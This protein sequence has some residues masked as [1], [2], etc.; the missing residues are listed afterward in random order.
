MWSWKDDYNAVRPHSGHGNLTPAGYADRSA[1]DTQRD[2]TLRRAR[3]V[4]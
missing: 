4:A 2:G 1:P 3:L